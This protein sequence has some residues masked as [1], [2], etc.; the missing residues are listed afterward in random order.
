MLVY[1]IKP[2]KSTFVVV[3]KQNVEKFKRV[4]ARV[5]MNNISNAFTRVFTF[6]FWIVLDCSNIDFSTPGH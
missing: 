1:Y 3:T 2:G 6:F 4:N 5:C